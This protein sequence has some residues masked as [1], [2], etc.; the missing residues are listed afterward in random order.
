MKKL[1]RLWHIAMLAVTLPLVLGALL[2]LAG[3]ANDSNRA[4]RARCLGA[5]HLRHAVHRRGRRPRRGIA[6]DRFLGAGTFRCT[7]WNMRGKAS[8]MTTGAV[9]WPSSPRR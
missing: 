8:S 1:A 4:R 6:L 2:R 5:R 7:S 9:E 3:A